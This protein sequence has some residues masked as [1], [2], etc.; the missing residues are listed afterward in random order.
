MRKLKFLSLKPRRKARSLIT[1]TPSALK[2]QKA[3]SNR[4]PKVTRNSPKAIMT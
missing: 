3:T 2:T 4:N 1:T